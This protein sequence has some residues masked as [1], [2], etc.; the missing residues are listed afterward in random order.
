MKQERLVETPVTQATH[1]FDSSLK[2]SGAQSNCNESEALLFRIKRNRSSRN[3]C[4]RTA[5][6]QGYVGKSIMTQLKDSN[7]KEPITESENV[8][9][10]MIANI[11]NAKRPKSR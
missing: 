4:N 2:L 1:L 11:Q 8:A 10:A 5:R 3:S 6:G 7:T 9:E